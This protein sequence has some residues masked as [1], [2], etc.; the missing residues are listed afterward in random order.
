MNS[1]MNQ[2]SGAAS[3]I[4]EMNL[5]FLSGMPSG[6]PDTTMDDILTVLVAVHPQPGTPLYPPYYMNPLGGCMPYPGSGFP[7][8]FENMTNIQSVNNIHPRIK[9]ISN[10]V[11]SHAKSSSAS[12]NFEY[13]PDLGAILHEGKCFECVHFS[14]HILLHDNH[15]KYLHTISVHHNSITKPLHKEIE[16]LSKADTVNTIR[17]KKELEASQA[18]ASTLVEQQNH[19]RKL[20]DDLLAKYQSIS[21]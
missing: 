18:Q 8:A 14:Q 16:R 3:S 21:Q 13:S 1:A 20:H 4:P 15:T 12:L 7:G 19:A 11:K 2:S 17:F 6:M 5:N 10:L 9:S